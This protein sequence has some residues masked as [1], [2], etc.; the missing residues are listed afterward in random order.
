MAL[1]LAQSQGIPSEKLHFMD[2]TDVV[3]SSTP[4]PGFRFS[5]YHPRAPSAL[6]STTST[7]PTLL[8]P[9]KAADTQNYHPHHLLLDAPTIISPQSK[10]GQCA[11]SCAPTHTA[12]PG[13]P[14]LRRTKY[15]A[16]G[17]VSLNRIMR[18]PTNMEH[19]G[20][21]LSPPLPPT[22]PV[23]TSPEAAAAQAGGASQAVQA[24]E[25]ST[26]VERGCVGQ[27]EV[28]TAVYGVFCSVSSCPKPRA[29]AQ[30]FMAAVGRCHFL[31]ALRC[32][33]C[34]VACW[35]DGL[36]AGRVSRTLARWVDASCAASK[37]GAAASCGHILQH[38]ACSI[39][40]CCMP[41]EVGAVATQWLPP[42]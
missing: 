32:D 19:S 1:L 36:A 28:M 29:H 8:A 15:L 9:S 7:C 6:G 5:G 20:G 10:C 39:R 41:V 42:P 35:A 30:C 23:S 2:I 37:L 31:V 40:A 38:P 17:Q 25:S 12:P 18:G 16:L 3:L 22:P 13:G 24:S 26:G 34:W 27:V 21:V 33:C 4:R 14:I 11:R